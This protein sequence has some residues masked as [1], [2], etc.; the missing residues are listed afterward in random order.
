MQN[1]LLQGS[2][3]EGVWFDMDGTL[4]DTVPD[5]LLVFNALLTRHGAPPLTAADLVSRFGPPEDVMLHR[6]LPQIDGL[7]L[8]G[9]MA[10]ESPRQPIA[11]YPGIAAIL[12]ACQ[13]RGARIGVFTGAGRVLGAARMARL[14]LQTWVEMLVT[15]DD[16]PRTKPH[17]DGLLRLSALLGCRLERSVYIGDSPL[18]VQAARAAGCK[19]VAVTWGVGSKA[20]LAAEKPDALVDTSAELAAVLGFEGLALGDKPAGR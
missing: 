12:A 4:A 18:D 15:A 11:P 3:W 10:A 8:R 1:V 19:A 7:Q 17:P 9:E 13:S 6:L 14:N 5:L 16:V 2:A 20:A